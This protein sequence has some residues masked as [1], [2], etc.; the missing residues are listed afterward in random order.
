MARKRL[1][2]GSKKSKLIADQAIALA[3]YATKALVA[4][5]QLR[6]RTKSVEGFPLRA[7]E[8]TTRAAAFP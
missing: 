3:D 5:E 8:R 7:P 1:I 4:A 2:G 6:I